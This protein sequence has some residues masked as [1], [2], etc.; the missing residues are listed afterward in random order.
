M[1]KQIGNLLGL[2]FIIAGFYFATAGSS[3]LR[4]E[5]SFDIWHLISL[6]APTF[7]MISS[8][9]YLHYR[10]F[11]RSRKAI[12]LFFGGFLVI[13]G[14]LTQIAMLLDIWDYI[15]PGFLFAI[16]FG[17]LECTILIRPNLKIIFAVIVLMILSV[18]FFVQTISEELLQE[19]SN[20]FILP[21]F[22]VILGIGVIVNN[23]LRHK[24]SQSNL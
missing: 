4:F 3:I 13:G 2:L 17:L 10:F 20:Q 5:T 22:L 18:L 16:A 6:F 1:N 15:W 23:T 14:G 12:T 7:V 21:S 11:V 24:K 9:L 8:G 19:N